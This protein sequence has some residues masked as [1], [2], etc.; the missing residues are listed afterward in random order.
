MKAYFRVVWLVALAF[1][2]VCAMAQRSFGE[3]PPLVDGSC[4]EYARLRAKRVAV[5]KDVELHV[6]QDK[7]YVWMCYSYPEGSFGTVDVKLKTAALPAPLNLH[8]SAQLGEWPA[9]KP[10]LA[11]QN[12]ESELWWN[13]VGWTANPV[14]INGMDRSGEKPRY[15]FKN[16]KARELQLS[17]RRFG[18][19]AW[20]FSMEIRS[21]KGG[22][23][24]L[25]DVVFPK[26]G[27]SYSLKVF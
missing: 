19:G 25:Y 2:S 17:K 6:Y 20:S 7:H 13:A 5:S 26:A 1:V 11:P 9:D 10:E 14:W 27:E 4:E 8:V 12:A 3:E 24:K 21:I 18:R 23:G 15:R 22:D 16:A